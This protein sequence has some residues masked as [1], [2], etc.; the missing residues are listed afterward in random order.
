MV[1]RLED[2]DVVLHQDLR[3][4]DG[5]WFYWYFAMRG[6]QGRELTF[7]FTRSRAIGL[8]GP[9]VS[10][11]GGKTWSW[12]GPAESRTSFRYRFAP[13]ET[14]VRFSFGMPYQRADLHRFIDRRRDSPFMTRETLGFTRKGTPVDML[15]IGCL[16]DD[17]DVRI[18]VTVRHHACEMMASYVLE[19]MIDA[20]L[21]DGDPGDWLRPRV[22]CVAI[23]MVDIDG[24]EAGDQGKN[25]LPRDHKADY[26][27]E[28]IY[29]EI[30]ALRAFIASWAKGRP[31]VTID[32]HN[33]GMGSRA[34]YTH[35]LRTPDGSPADPQAPER[36]FLDTLEA[37]HRGP[38]RFRTRD[39]VEFAARIANREPGP[40]PA[41][42]AGAE[43][44]GGGSRISIGFEIPYAM[45]GDT[46]VTPET[47]RA[48][49]RDLALALAVFL[50][51][52]D[53]TPRHP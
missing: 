38:L 25:R 17:P 41:P 4:T 26:K 35:A 50:N 27:G 14:E 24:V 36:K 22:Q 21:D 45:V 15:K 51:R 18:L 37:V 29:P 46:A 23:P 32:L 20:F 2:N 53:A 31:D 9:G 33:P 16:R 48:F 34:I 7:H 11:D 3:D 30:A 5:D 43:R 44:M 42:D 28:S 8:L 47:A 52:P 19:G 40:D 10:R 1:E 12:L 39:S 49:G 6:A 13:D